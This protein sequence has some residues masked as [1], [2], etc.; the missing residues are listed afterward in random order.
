MCLEMRCCPGSLVMALEVGYCPGSLP[1]F[2]VVHCC[3]G[4]LPMFLDI[5][6]CFGSLP[7]SLQVGC[8]P[9]SLPMSLEVDWK[10]ANLAGSPLL[11]WKSASIPG[12]Q[13]LPWKSGNAPGRVHYC[14]ESLPM[15]LEVNWCRGSLPASVEVCCCPGSLPMSLEVCWWSWKSTNHPGSV[16]LPLEVCDR[17]QKLVLLSKST[18][19]ALSIAEVCKL[20]VAG[21]LTKAL[22][23]CQDL[24]SAATTRSQL[25]PMEVW[26]VP[27][28]SLSVTWMSACHDTFKY[29]NKRD[30][31]KPS[32]QQILF[33]DIQIKMVISPQEN[34]CISNGS[35][36]TQNLSDLDF[37]FSRSFNVK[38][39]GAIGLPTYG[40]LLMFN[41]NI[42]PKCALLW[43]IRLQIWMT[44]T[45]TSVSQGQIWWCSWTPHIWLPIVSNINHMSISECLEVMAAQ[46]ILKF[47]PI[48]HH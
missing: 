25:L 30:S 1:M 4:S 36:T 13:L 31:R 21:C 35:P 19:V 2:L 8:C 47:S 23:F 22:E 12:H 38:Y 43:D 18:N 11:S 34:I 45:L 33:Y 24:K 9:G 16:L 20:C 5:S 27:C 41:S 7:A 32:C 39:E 28:R 44:L 29:R 26:Q 10:S 15:F 40:F 48:S 42:G 46:K 3:P 14:P 37:D 6:C 17:P